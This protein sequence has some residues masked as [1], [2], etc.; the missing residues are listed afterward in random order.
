MFSLVMQNIVAAVFFACQMWVVSPWRPTRS[1]S[2]AE[3]RQIFRFSANLT[4]FNLLNFVSRNADNTII[5]R[6][7]GSAALGVYSANAGLWVA[8]V[9]N[10]V[11]LF[12]WGTILRHR[13]AGTPA[14]LVAAGLTTASLG[15]VLV[16]L[17]ALL[18]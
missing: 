13:A 14:Q 8:I 1:F 18:H 9:A 6:V 11:L 7:M 12:A 4:G 17:K 10:T 15:L 2:F 5:G 3:L 16:L